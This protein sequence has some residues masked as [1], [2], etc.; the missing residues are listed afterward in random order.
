[1][2]RAAHTLAE[3]KISVD[4][5]GNGIQEGASI[6]QQVVRI[7]CKIEAEIA[8]RARSANSLQPQG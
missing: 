7:V 3:Q 6:P 2:V 1:V 8:R 4:P 5:E